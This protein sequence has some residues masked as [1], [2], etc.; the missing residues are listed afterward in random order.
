MLPP[1]VDNNT[2]IVHILGDTSDPAIVTQP[3]LLD[4]QE[5]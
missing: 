4:E 3:H 5:L 2:G 1:R